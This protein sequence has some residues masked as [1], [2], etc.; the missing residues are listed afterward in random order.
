MRSDPEPSEWARVWLR[1]SLEHR[2]ED[3]W[4]WQ[5]L[6]DATSGDPERAWP[7]VLELLAQAPFERLGYVGAGPLETIVEDHAAAFIDR[8]EEAAAIDPRFREMLG[9]VWLNSWGIDPGLVARLVTASAGRIEV[10]EF[11]PEEAEAEAV[12]MI[13]RAAREACDGENGPRG[14]RLT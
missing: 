2:P 8:I 7:V 13:D 12:R 10:Q 6:A 14:G 5:S 11:D 4:A 1:H 9:A 3:F